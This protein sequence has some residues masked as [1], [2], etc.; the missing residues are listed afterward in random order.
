MS[1]FLISSFNIIIIIILLCHH[2]LIITASNYRVVGGRETSIN[3]VK[4]MVSLRDRNGEYFCGGTLVKSRYVI[5]A[6]HC[7]KE[8]RARDIVVH[9]GTTYLHQ[10]GLTSSVVRVSIPP[11]FTY[12]TSNMDIAVLKL[13]KPLRGKNIAT[14]PLCSRKIPYRSLVKVSGWGSIH[15]NTLMPSD[16]LRTVN[17]RI[18]SRKNCIQNYRF[19]L[20]ITNLMM[21]ASVAG[22]KDAC[23][24]DSGGPLVY[25]GELCGV[26]SFG[27]GCARINFPGVYTSIFAVKKYLQR[28]LRR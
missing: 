24:G 1:R 26:V 7:V 14:I 12:R 21:C 15:E 3:N 22:V 17:V 2:F 18:T 19:V 6:A 25:R 13:R 5:T 9:A 20:K 10:K 28:Q 4:Y 23:V 11:R 27:I 8:M 16:R